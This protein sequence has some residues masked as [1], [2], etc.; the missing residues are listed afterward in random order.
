MS[1]RPW[2]GTPSD[3]W[4]AASDV[5]DFIPLSVP[6]ISG[7]EW[8]YVKECLDGGWVSSV[9]EYVTRFEEMS[10]SATGSRHAVATTS[11]TAAL[12]LAL[13]LAG[14]GVDEEVILP[15]LT[16]IASA[17]AVRYQGAW[18]TFVDSDEH[19]QID[20]EAVRRFLVEDCHS[21]AVNRHTGRS[22]TAIMP[23]HV[24]GHPC[25]IDEIRDIGREFGLRVIED[26]AEALGCRYKDRPVGSGG[27][28]CLSFNGNK[29]L[30]TGGG[31]MLL[32]DDE[33]T[34]VRGRYLSTQAKDDAVQYVHGEVGFNYRLSNVQA[35]IGCAQ[36]ERL[37]GFVERKRSIASLY[38]EELG[39]LP[40]V[41]T[42]GEAEWATS[43]FWLYTVLIDPSTGH[44]P[45]SLIDALARERIQ[46]RPVWQPM[47]LSP[48]HRQS[49]SAPCERT[50]E[51]HA[52]AV[53]LPC[54]TSLTH[55]EQ[56][57]VVDVVSRLLRHG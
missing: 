34:A 18:P 44:T 22:V 7:N 53:S 12:H 42:M 27:L 13:R 10:A 21:G 6:N 48:A 41:T 43:T 38:A 50:E 4:C 36:L 33:E 20:P 2:S 35:A 28:A 49:H 11:G 37:A 45:N 26:A 25:D 55:A 39:R 17:N 51:V 5:S 16:F 52:R 56:T 46:A 32:T 30:T 31:G 40:G 9:G 23:V 1:G 3:S 47:H 29:I 15:S 19:F 8:E 57:R 14:V 54:S 24:L